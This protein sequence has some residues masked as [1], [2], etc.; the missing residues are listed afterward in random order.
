MVESEKTLS[1]DELHAKHLHFLKSRAPSRI[2][3]ISFLCVLVIILAV[4]AWFLQTQFITGVTVAP[5]S[6]AL[7]V[8]MEQRIASLEQQVQVLDTKLR[9]MNARVDKDASDSASVVVPGAQP[10]PTPTVT[11]GTTAH[12]QDDLAAL[13]ASL[14]ALQAEVKQNSNSAAQT[15]QLTQDTLAASIAYTQL[16]ETA[17][18]GRGFATELTALRSV[19]GNNKNFQEPLARLEPYTA[20]GAPTIAVLREEFVALKPA[21][22]IAADKAIAQDWEHRL[23]A[24]LRGFISIRP[25]HGTAGSEN[26]AD[27]LAASE[28][29][30]ESGDLSGALDTIKI[31]PTEA[32]DVL[33]NWQEKAKARL[34]ID[35]A[36]H[37]LGDRFITHPTHAQG[38]P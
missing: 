25:L 28:V 2:G 8:Q 19:V 11:A 4:A 26:A 31:L 12:M 20:Q 17:L 30:I 14:A 5:S 16:R 29:A 37:D 24:D 35:A 33:K 23:L 15:Q 27:P 7:V 1:D 21:A 3:I 22:D 9:E 34:A 38:E 32:Q 18:T 36:L 6:T 10:A 13:S